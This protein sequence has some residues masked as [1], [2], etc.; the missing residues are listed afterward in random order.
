[1]LSTAYNKWKE[2]PPL[3][4]M[5]IKLF[6]LT[7]PK[8]NDTFQYAFTLSIC[9]T[10]S[11]STS[12]TSCNFVVVWVATPYGNT[13]GSFKWN[14]Q[15]ND[16]EN[17]FQHQEL[18]VTSKGS[19]QIC[20]FSTLSLRL[21]HFTFNPHACEFFCLLYLFDFIF[22]SSLDSIHDSIHL[23]LFGLVLFP[24]LS[25]IFHSSV[26]F[27]CAVALCNFYKYMII[28]NSLGAQFITSRCTDTHH[29]IHIPFSNCHALAAGWITVDVSAAAALAVEVPKVASMQCRLYTSPDIR[30]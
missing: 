16:A 3:G 22:H 11:S 25:S 10:S 23:R 2:K 27:F 30:S 15:N 7:Q 20:A 6:A 14:V 28:V 12:S 19:V 4:K 26:P 17:E 24:P 1:M 13:N 5:L 21:I 9:T 8:R 29:F 18:W